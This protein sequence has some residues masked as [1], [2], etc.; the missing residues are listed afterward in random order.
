MNLDKQQQF[1]IELTALLN[2]YSAENDSD[3]PDFILAAY[4]ISCLNAF[5]STVQS[6]RHWWGDKEITG[7]TFPHIVD[8]TTETAATQQ[9]VEHS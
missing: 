2:R 1:G 3:T 6:R 7:F 4:L 5:H 8:V 9:E